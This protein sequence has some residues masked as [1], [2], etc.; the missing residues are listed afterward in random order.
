MVDNET[1]SGFRAQRYLNLRKAHHAVSIISR[2]GHEEIRH[3]SMQMILV[4]FATS[5]R[6]LHLGALSI[7]VHCNLHYICQTEIEVNR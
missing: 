4:H 3:L 5:T 6:F 2:H 7:H 1:V